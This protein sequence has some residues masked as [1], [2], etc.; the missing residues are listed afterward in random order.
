MK[1]NDLLAKCESVFRDISIAETQA[2][3]LNVLILVRI[4]HFFK[5][6]VTLISV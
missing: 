6:Q 5:L 1:F 4:E 2:K 3:N